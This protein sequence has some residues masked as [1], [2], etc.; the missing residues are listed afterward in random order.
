MPRTNKIIIR[1]GTAAPTASDFV[2]GEPAWDKTNGKF[3]IKNT[4]GTMVEIGAGGGG[5]TE[6]YEVATTASLPSPGTAGRLYVTTDTARVYRWDSTNSVWVEVGAVSSYDSRWDLFL[7]AAPTGVSGT[8][9]N[10]QVALAWTAPSVSSQTPIVSYTVQYSTNSG[11][12]WTTWGTAP[13]TNSATITSLT[14]GTAYTFRVLATNAVG[15][16]AYSSASASVTPTN[17]VSVTYLLVGGGGGGGSAR[18]AG[19]GAGGYLYG[20]G[21]A[22][23]GSAL[24]VVVGSGG[25]GGIHSGAAA[26]AGGATSFPL[27]TGTLTADG[28]GRGAEGLYGLSYGVAQAG[29]TGGSG[30]GGSGYT[31]VGAGG[32]ATSGQGYA[33]GSGYSGGEPYNGGGGGGAGAAG[34]SG[35]AAAGGN[36]KSSESTFL[37]AASAGVD[38]SGTRW[39]AGGG[40]AGTYN[41]GASNGGNGGGGAGGNNVAGTAG[42]AN[43]GGGGGGGGN[44]AN[45]AAGGSG[46]A[47]IRVADSITASA[48]TGSPTVYVTGGFRY[49]KF[50][51][52]GTITF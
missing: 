1:S 27:S 23:S 9:G 8:A 26:T 13:T 25:T 15:S 24:S 28:G 18:G 42:T 47:I 44:M 30:G 19:G 3:Y 16:S 50:T 49:Y 38:I 10:Q 21:S 52:N 31:P 11:S 32:A 43:T 14:N 12:T 45:G 17:T 7:P 33:G 51:G 5:A 29:G 34:G 6:I 35:A 37:A 48:T 22:L 36:G 46:I 40:A 4:A 41:Y 2:T 20:S 39:I